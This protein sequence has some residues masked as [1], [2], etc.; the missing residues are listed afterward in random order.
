MALVTS[1]NL[2]K[3]Q[4]AFPLLQNKGLA[5]LISVEWTLLYLESGSTT[6]CM[7]ACVFLRKISHVALARSSHCASTIQS[8]HNKIDNQPSEMEEN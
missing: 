7:R 3:K 5:K 6:D 8:S 2:S 1:T 4:S